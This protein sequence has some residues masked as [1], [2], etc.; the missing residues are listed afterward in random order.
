[1]KMALF[2]LFFLLCHPVLFSSSIPID[3][4]PKT[5]EIVKKEGLE[6]DNNPFA[7]AVVWQEKEPNLLYRFKEG[8]PLIEAKDKEFEVATKITD[9]LLLK[10]VTAKD[11]NGQDITKNLFVKKHN[12]HSAVAGEYFCTYGVKDANGKEAEKTIQVSIVAQV[13]TAPSNQAGVIVGSVF[14]VVATLATIGGVIYLLVRKKQD[15]QD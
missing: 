13:I 15:I 7:S 8:A 14:G 9:E 3:I 5:Q 11:E 6:E 2:A 12:I 10:G 1:M 4:Q